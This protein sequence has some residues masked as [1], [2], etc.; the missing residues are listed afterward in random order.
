[1]SNQKNILKI[2]TKRLR[3]NNWSLDLSLDEAK[4]NKEVIQLGDSQTL[5]FID[6]ILGI[7]NKD[8]EINNIKDKIK[9][10]KKQENTYENKKLIKELNKKKNELKYNQDY[11]CIV[12]DRKSDF[13]KCN[14]KC[15]FFVNGKQYIRLLGTTGGIK[16]ETIVYVSKNVYEQLK[17]KIENGRD[18]DKPLVPAKLEAYKALSCSMSVPVRNPKGILVVDDCITNFKD[19]I[20]QIDDSQGNRPEMKIIEDFDVELN[21]SDGYGLISP[22]LSKLWGVDIKECELTDRFVPSGF[23]IRNAFTKGMV[24][25][26][27]FKKFA[28]QVAHNY[29]VKDVWGQERDIR[30]V[31]LILTTSMLKL[32]DSYKSLEHYLSCCKN[33]GW[34]FSVTKMCPKE[35]ENERTLNYQFLQSF[36]LGDEDIQE[37]IKPTVDSIKDSLGLD[38]AKSLLFL[39]GIKINDKNAFVGENDYV[40][41]LMIDKRLIN[42]PYVQDRIYNMRKKRIQDAKVGV[43]NIT[44][45]Y[46]IIS[47][48][49]YSLCQHIFGL[50]VTGILKA[51]ECYSKYWLD[52]GS[53]EILAFRAPMTCH[54][55]IRKINITSND[56]TK[57]WYKYMYT[58]LILNSWDTTTHA[59][60][61]ADKDSDAFITTDNEV[62]LRNYKELLAIFCVQK[63]AKKV[64]VKEKDLIQCNKDGFGDEIGT[65]TNRITEMF[66]VL[67]KFNKDSEEYKELM[68]RIMCGQHYQ[69]CAIDKIKG[70]KSNPM[71]KEWYD[72]KSNR[73]SIDKE[74]GEIL[75]DD[76]TIKIKQFNTRIVANKKPYFFIYIYPELKNTYDK[77]I[78]ETNNKCISQFGITTRELFEKEDKSEDEINFIKY[79][80]F[81][82]PVSNNDCVMNKI[83]RAIEFE[84]KG[85]KNKMKNTDFDY[86]ILKTTKEYNK[87]TYNKVKKIYNSYNEELAQ[88]KIISKKHK[89]SKDD[90][91]S[92]MLILKENF[93]ETCENICLNEEE[94]CNIIIDICYKTNKS[95]QFAWDIC[96]EQIIKNL[97]KKNNY[98]INYPVAN[99][100]GE[101]EFGGNKFSLETKQVRK[102]IM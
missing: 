5:R 1:M 61:G 11:L 48:D 70:I 102:E 69:Q 45:N 20:I 93:K 19:N 41:A 18:V 63:S 46:A 44:G 95:K 43:L 14:R 89:I 57:K 6:S 99:N 38:Y 82:N 90:K 77:F 84:F 10:L 34:T 78:K 16:N 56:M 91:Y 68:Y 33:N 59:E 83:C 75:D 13:D 37:L 86:N 39:R 62:L 21:D 15:S 36:E 97:L 40:K 9:E 3:K 74:T 88:Y 49:P 96:G 85:I 25:T 98:I 60:N 51:K 26:F 31:D 47:G 73:I 22:Q 23:C 72:L 53:R 52:K 94:L 67:A 24:F 7:E 29:I 55:N 81:K 65:T 71:P 42:D 79:Y 50:K 17:K 101:I 35:L 12:I 100:D 87:N 58:C 54:N 4:K 2:H 32:W 30:K 28:K 27:N 80:N 92:S 76:K 8:E 64:Q 66:D